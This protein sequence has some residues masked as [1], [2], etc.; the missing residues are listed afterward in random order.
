MAGVDVFYFDIKA[1]NILYN[2]S[3]DGS[4]NVFLGDLGSALPDNRGDYAATFPPPCSLKKH[5][6]KIKELTDELNELI[7]IYQQ[8]HTPENKQKAIEVLNLIDAHKSDRGIINARES[9]HFEKIYAWQL[10]V[11]AFELLRV[12]NDA[13]E[14]FHW[15]GFQDL[16]MLQIIIDTL[17]EFDNFGLGPDVDTKFLQRSLVI[18]PKD[19]ISLSE[20]L[21]LL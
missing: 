8:N 19:R 11:L 20:M 3:K 17:E 21:E 5:S 9:K 10:A 18:N 2:C 7:E 6:S 13:L 12:P 4:I 1:Q 14:H 15:S 16:K